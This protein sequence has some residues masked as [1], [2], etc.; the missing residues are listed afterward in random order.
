MIHLRRIFMVSAALVAIH[1]QGCGCDDDKKYY[2]PPQDQSYTVTGTAGKGILRGFNVEAYHFT[3]SGIL[4]PTPISTTITSAIGRYSLSIP[5]IY[6]NLP[7]V[8]RV[9]PRPTDSFMTCDLSTGCG[10]GVNFGQPYEITDSSFTLETVVPSASDNSEAN[11][12]LLTTLAAQLAQQAIE[13]GASRED[14]Q[15][16]INAANSSVANRFGLAGDL[17]TMP[18]I[19]LTDPAAVT[20]AMDAGNSN[21]VQ[22]AALNSAIVQAARLDDNL[23]SFVGA[24][25]SFITYFADEGVAGNTTDA[26]ETSLADILSAARA[27]LMQVQANDPQAPQGLTALLQSLF[28]DQQ[29]AESE[30]ADGRST[31]TPSQTSGATPIAKVKA[32]VSD[33][34]NLAISLGD[35]ALSGGGTIGG[36]SEDFAMQLEAAEMASSENAGYLIEAMAIAAAAIDDANRAHG[37]NSELTSYTSDTGV[38][39]TIVTEGESSVFSVDDDIEVETDTGMV[40]IAVEL[41]AADSLTYEETDSANSAEMSADGEYEVSGSATSSALTMSVEE[42]SSISIED[43]AVVESVNSQTGELSESQTLDALSFNLMIELSQVETDTV[44]DPVTLEGTLIASLSD[45]MIVDTESGTTESSAKSLGMVS[46]KLS[47][48][49][50]NTSGESASFAVSVS[51]DGTGVSFVESWTQQGETSTGET[52]SN[53]VDMYGSVAFTAELTGNP[54]V[55]SMNYSVAR[56]G[57]EDADNSL[58]IRY[59]GKQFRFNMLVADG[60]P[61]GN[62]TITNHDGVIMSLMETTVEGE[63]RLQGTISLNGTQYATVE[64]DDTV[65]IR[66]TDESFESL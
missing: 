48:L 36:I 50:S 52:T 59:P 25:N 38:D 44:T 10:V 54:N 63:S 53:F 8:L 20:A 6:I 56:T 19:D 58:T 46:L 26:A 15:D 4:D 51:G 31:G 16:A 13:S 64:E 34:K 66:Y 18:V 43:M 21:L 9:T 62:L 33:L 2:P 37:N 30:P 17:T 5:D 40:I 32:M 57:L 61:E 14:I 28:V 55:V 42:G 1:M 35:T 45:V 49:V 60:A 65:V 23:L 11:I 27:V 47:G 29:L 24:L 7:L 39:V 3:D 41:D 22:Y 12:T